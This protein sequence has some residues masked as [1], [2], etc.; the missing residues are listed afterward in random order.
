L[1]CVVVVTLLLLP[2]VTFYCLRCTLL[3]GY[4]RLIYGCVL[5]LRWFTFTLRLCPVGWLL[6]TLFRVV[7]YTF[8]THVVVVGCYVVV[9]T[10]FPVLLV[11][12]L[13]L[14]LRLV[15]LVW[16]DFALPTFTLL[17]LVT[18]CLLLFPV[19][20]GCPFCL[21]LRLRLLRWLRCYVVAVR[22]FCCVVGCYVVVVT[23]V[24][25]FTLLRCTLLHVCCCFDLLLLFDLLFTGCC[26]RW[27]YV[28]VVTHAFGLVVVVVYSCVVV[29]YIYV[30]V[31]IYVVV[32]GYR[33]DRCGWLRLPLYVALRLRCWLH[34]LYVVG[35]CVVIR[36]VALLLRALL[37][38][39]CC[40]LRYRTVVTI[41][42]YRL[43]VV[44]WL[45][46]LRLVFALVITLSVGLIYVRV[47]CCYT[48]LHVGW[49]PRL[50]LRLPFGYIV[51]WLHGWLRLVVV[52]F[53]RCVGYLRLRYG[54][55]LRWIRLLLVVT[56]R[57]LRLV[58]FTLFGC[59]ALLVTFVVT[60]RCYGWLRLRLLVAFGC[61]LPVTVVVVAVAL[62]CCC[63]YVCCC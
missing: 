43:L 26:P 46:C 12:L 31:F 42:C 45:I 32:T 23:F 29:I 28:Y 27:L 52:G 5:R 13:L 55:L 50:R 8:T 56:F 9:V 53:T 40:W 61:W 24:F 54:W 17:R 36:Y 20:F 11:T 33:L 51:G 16:F 58:V 1:F 22:L 4:A 18:F 30:V 10:L 2:F 62:R 57:L 39:V 37:V 3:F 19:C 35:C 34:T 44:V 14:T 48:L 38:Y 63:C 47:C 49:L 41:G 7:G 60:H 21:R 15:T 6:F 59:Y 25:A